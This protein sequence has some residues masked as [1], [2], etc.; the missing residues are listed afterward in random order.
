MSGQ[1]SSN[2]VDG[3]VAG[4]PAVPAPSQAVPAPHSDL[5][6]EMRALRDEI[7]KGLDQRL[8]KFGDEFQDFQDRMNSRILM[9]Q[10]HLGSST[11]TTPSVPDVFVGIPTADFLQPSKWTIAQLARVDRSALRATW[12]SEIIEPRLRKCTSTSV[13]RDLVE[14]N[15]AFGVLLR[16][17]ESYLTEHKTR[18]KTMDE[19]YWKGVSTVFEGIC[20]E[21]I[22]Q[23]DVL[24]E[25]G[26]KTA[27]FFTDH[28]EKIRANDAIEKRKKEAHAQSSVYE[29]LGIT[30]EK[31]RSTQQKS[32]SA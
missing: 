11:N 6:E 26:V 31:A 18:D 28:S 8:T 24:V 21:K 1:Q 9:M 3:S 17:V 32:T 7:F 15:K 22:I 12:K 23:C 20:I 30:L 4:S 2:P 16:A 5:T 10:E 13:E 29:Q 14:A 19:A 25:G 27:A